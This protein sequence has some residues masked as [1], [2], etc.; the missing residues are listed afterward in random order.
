MN[1]VR[2]QF[3]PLGAW[4]KKPTPTRKRARFSVGYE[5]TLRDLTKAGSDAIPDSFKSN[6]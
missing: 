4:P 1:K 2:Y 5:A 3:E 6:G